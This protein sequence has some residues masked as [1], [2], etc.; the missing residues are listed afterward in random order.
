M[1]KRYM[2]DCVVVKEEDGYCASFPQVPGAFADGDT[3]E[4]AISNAAEA[5]SAFLADD[6]NNGVVPAAYMRSAEVVT[7][8][9]ELDTSGARAAACRTFKQAAADLKV[10]PPRVTALVKAGKLEVQL[11][12][13]RRMITI[14]SIERYAG[15]ERHAGRPKGFAAVE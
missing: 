15:Q 13:G 3:R 11:V 1:G 9:V 6:I 12:D 4:E 5:L 14:E 7:L 8:S 10:T 2:Y